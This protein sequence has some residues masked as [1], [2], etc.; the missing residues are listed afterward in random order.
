M[1]PS[2][3]GSV[4]RAEQLCSNAEAQTLQSRDPVTMALYHK[5]PWYMA[6][7]AQGFG[8]L[9]SYLVSTTQACGL[10]ANHQAVYLGCAHSLLGIQTLAAAAVECILLTEASPNMAAAPCPPASSPTAHGCGLHLP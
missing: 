4:F 2:T 10:G 3:L 9:G 5:A 6:I 1:C 8:N 7:P